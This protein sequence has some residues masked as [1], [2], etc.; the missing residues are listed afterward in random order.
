M[1]YSMTGFVSLKECFED[2]EIDIKLKSLNGKSLEI[3]LKGDKL[4]QN[5]LELEVRKLAQRYFERGTLSLIVNINYKKPVINIEPQ[6][7]K[8]VKEHLE[9][10]FKQADIVPSPDKILD[11][12]ISYLQNPLQEL[13]Q[14]L[15]DNFLIVLDKAFSMLKEERKK[16]GQ[17]LAEDIKGRLELILKYITDIEKKKDNIVKL[18]QRRITDKIKQ[19]LGEEFSERAFI[20]A[21][22]I[23]QKMDITEEIVRLKNHIDN[24]FELIKADEPIGRKMDFLCQEMHRE[25]NTLGNKMPDFSSMVVDIKTQIEKIRQQ[26]QNIE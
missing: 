7:L 13:D 17:T 20:E 1:P 14:S 3:S 8:E 16:E 18:A 2:Y 4:I 23:A 24:F 22:I 21:S 6:K 25:I 19:L 26:V 11:Y 9:S 12:S 5:F 10:I 15:R